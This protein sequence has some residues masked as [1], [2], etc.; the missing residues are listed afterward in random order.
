MTA[1][2][3]QKIFALGPDETEYRKL[4][5][6]HVS[7][8]SWNGREFLKVASEGLTALAAAAMDDLAFLLRPSHLAQL[9]GR[10]HPQ[11]L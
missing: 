5:S 6:D 3:Y 7:V 9:A 10:T 8:A 1:F 2:E 11:D 4:T